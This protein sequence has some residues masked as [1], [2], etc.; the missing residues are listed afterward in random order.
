MSVLF[1]DVR[2]SVATAEQ[3]PPAAVAGRINA[4]LDTATRVITDN[5]GF[6]MAFYGDCV[7]AV[8][9]PGFSGADHAEKALAAARALVAPGAMPAPDGR[10]I[11]IGVGL[12]AGPVQICTVK[13]ATGLF[14][15][16][17]IFGHNVNIAARLASAAGPGEA[18]A[19]RGVL[20]R[21][22]ADGGRSEYRRFDLKG[23]T[24]RVEAA[25][26]SP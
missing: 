4:F 11:A 21:V 19:S 8:W 12:H 10:P 16:V 22:G 1:V 7:V 24:D 15:D 25:S 17:S 6:I 23:I 3:L 5:D 13:A 18:L 20:D 9:P 26:L 14:R 2:N